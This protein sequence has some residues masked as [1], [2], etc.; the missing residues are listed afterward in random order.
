MVVRPQRDS[1]WTGSWCNRFLC[2]GRILMHFVRSRWNL[3]SLQ[4]R[5]EQVGSFLLSYVWQE[6]CLP[7]CQDAFVFLNLQKQ[8]CLCLGNWCWCFSSKASWLRKASDV[9]CSGTFQATTSSVWRYNR[10]AMERWLWWCWCR[11]AWVNEPAHV[12]RHPDSGRHKMLNVL[13]HSRR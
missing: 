8:Q 9:E 7:I 6:V 4:G 3:T 11:W 13:V 2:F 10:H 12:Q 5:F 1:W